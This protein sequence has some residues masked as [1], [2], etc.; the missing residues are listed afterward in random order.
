MTGL[1]YTHS[2]ADHFGG[3][4]G[5]LEQERVDSGEVP[6]I[7]PAGFTEH[8]VAENVFAGT[9]MSR[10]AGYMYGAALD[11]GPLGQVG[12]GLGQTTSVG[13]VTLIPPTVHV[14]TTGQEVVVDGVRMVFQLALG[15]ARRR[16]RCISCCPTC[17]RCAWR[18]TPPTCSTTS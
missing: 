4:R 17:G 14:T 9:A 12:A 6:V 5:V 7:A 3:A 18:R 15:P 11:R 10:R 8:A 16:P 2:H 13:S 1:V